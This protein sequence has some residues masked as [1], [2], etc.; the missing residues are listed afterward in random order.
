VTPGDSAISAVLELSSVSKNY[1]A[2]RPLRIERLVV[3]P[4]QQVAIA[5]LDQP[6]AEVFINLITG[7][8]LP[9]SGTVRVFDRAT[10]DIVDSS[11]W[12]STLDRF[13]IVS[14]RAAL[15]DMLSVVQNLAVPFSLEIEPPPDDIRRQAL[16]LAREVG[17]SE[18]TWERRAG[19]LSAAS[20]QRVRLAR[21][22]A[23]GPEILVLEHPSASIARGDVAP[24]AR[25]VRTVAERRGI[26]AI[27]LTADGAFASAVAPRTLTVDP[28]TGR[29]TEPRFGKIKF[30]S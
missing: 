8:S 18:S 13:G 15:L 28:A 19:D 29:L 22:L 3:T 27:S 9:D 11:D 20:R 30:W 17:L 26:A 14:E 5:G 2:L 4:G 7:A 12:L 25:D 23:L 24:L 21:A 10:A 1:G 16:D 6:A